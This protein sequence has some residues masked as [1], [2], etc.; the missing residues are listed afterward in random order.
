MSADGQM[1][2]RDRGAIDLAMERF[3][4]GD[5]RAFR[6]IHDELA[7]RL[8]GFLRRFAESEVE[9]LVQ[10]TFLQI[11]LARGTFIRGA[12]VKPWAYAIA[13]RLLIDRLR[14][15]K[16]RARS[17]EE[18][19]RLDATR[20]AVGGPDEIL[21]ARELAAELGARL[22]RLPP[23]RREV[24]ELTRGAGVSSREAASVLGI[25]VAAVKLRAARAMKT[26]RQAMPP[27]AD[28]APARSR[29]CR[30]A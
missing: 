24:L 10:Q 9:D 17:L 4:G 13:R 20:L 7:P 30:R 3:A 6:E 27:I 18:R 2:T 19:L 29:S 16:T 8:R 28:L 15:E 11:H 14:R 12:R 22:A 25:T 1:L 23:A 21:F 5:D 26:L